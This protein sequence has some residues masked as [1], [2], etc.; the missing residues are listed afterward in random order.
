V[1]QEP[2]F[3]PLSDT[4]KDYLRAADWV[5]YQC[6][7]EIG[8]TRTA[9]FEVHVHRLDDCNSAE[10]GPYGNDV[11]LLCSQCA[12]FVQAQLESWLR[13]VLFGGWGGFE[14]RTCGAPVAEIG[15]LVR[16]MKTLP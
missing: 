4:E 11:A 14:C 5:T 12:V 2:R 6:Q 3:K 9:R 1:S 16:E 13:I 15:D 10:T 7:S 8:C